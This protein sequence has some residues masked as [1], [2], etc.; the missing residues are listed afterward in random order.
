MSPAGSVVHSRTP[1]RAGSSSNIFADAV[2]PAGTLD[3]DKVRA[4]RNPSDSGVRVL[5]DKESND[6]DVIRVTKGA[7][8]G[9]KMP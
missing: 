9:R 2:R 8:P 7:E 3:M 4:R 1:S 5:L 6:E